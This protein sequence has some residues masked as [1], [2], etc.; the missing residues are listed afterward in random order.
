MRR[1]SR[2]IV[3]V[4]LFTA[5]GFAQ[6]PHGS[7]L[8]IDCASCHTTSDW[9]SIPDEIP[10]NHNDAT[11]F[12]LDG[13]HQWVDCSSCHQSLIFEEAQ[14][15]CLSCHLDVH[16]QSV[17]ANCTRCHTSDNWLVF[18]TV[19]LHQGIGFPL[20]GNHRGL[21]CVECH[22]SGNTLDYSPIGTDCSSCHMDDYQATSN[23]NH[24]AAGF[25]TDCLEC[26]SL[27]TTGWN[28]ASLNHDFF[29]LEKGH[30]T[31]NCT[32]C[33]DLNNYSNVS[34]ECISCHQ[35]DFNSASD[36]NHLAS[37]FPNDCASCHTID[38][39]WAPATFNHDFF[40]L[41]S[42]HDI[43]DCAA[44]HTNNQFEG[45][46]SECVSC[47]L[48][49]FNATVNPNHS[50]A[51]YTQNCAVCHSTNPGWA[52]ASVNHDFFPLTLGHDI[53][54]CTACHTN[55]SYANTSSD[56]VSCHQNDYEATL[57]PNHSESGFPTDCASCHSTNPGWAPATVNHDF[58]PLTLG[59]DIQDC[60]ACH[61]NGTYSGTDPNCVSCHQND[62]D[63][64]LDPNHSEVG[65][66]ND[67][68]SCHT[69]NPGWA[70]A[71]INHDFFP[72]T[73]GHDIQDCT[74]CHT[75]GTY[76]GTDPNCF[77]CHQD[78]YN[79][80]NDPNHSAA[81]FPTDCVLC[82]T[83]NP[84]WQPTTFDHDNQYFPIYSGEHRGEWNSCTDC[85]TNASDY[86]VFTCTTCHTKNETDGE[87]DEVSGY[88][89][90]SN[91]C[92]TCHPNP[93]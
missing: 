30:N 85:H 51:G 93:D 58:F 81:A 18:N 57:E 34:S 42:G 52:P 67:C 4:L 7:A 43:Q 45:T 14:D 49:N 36:P 77:S 33:H 83:T 20:E 12:Q 82:H 71:S 60:T 75:N 92:F 3:F 56:C 31:R 28:L 21:S 59:H 25:S 41:T 27:E 2:I 35:Q 74:A 69:T 46:S 88:V 86:S 38:P 80:T 8:T 6:S 16:E 10:F 23:P 37:N 91:A 72:L 24:S 84:G 32:L 63:G 53:Q 68:A 26:H 40:P 1:L 76:S 62:Y 15:N 11:N 48:D 5:I 87:H 29:P 73:L 39:G 47:H 9:N 78:D 79:S 64:T 61:T 44:C 13:A 50:N 89:Y 55:G 17:G 54:D 22:D 19:E 66:S 65:F 90:E 70:P